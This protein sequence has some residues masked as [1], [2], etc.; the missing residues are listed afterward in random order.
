MAWRGDDSTQVKPSR[1][2]GRG[3]VRLTKTRGRPRIV[4]RTCNLHLL[5]AKCHC[6]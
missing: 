2:S 6:H 5:S 3:M 4:G 1:E